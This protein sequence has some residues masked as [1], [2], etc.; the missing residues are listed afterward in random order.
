[1][2]MK[3]WIPLLVFIFLS[4]KGF[5]QDA[6]VYPANVVKINLSSLVLKNI[7]L[8]Y[9]RKLS[10]RISF[11]LGFRIM[12][13]GPIPFRS[14]LLKKSN[15]SGNDTSFKNSITNSRLGGW[16]LTGEVRFYM[17]KKGFARSFYIAPFVRYAQFSL[18]I[19]YT[20][21]DQNGKPYN[22]SLN[23]NL[24]GIG[25]G[26]LLGK[27]WLIGKRVSVDLWL[28]GPF[29]G[30]ANA[31]ANA[32]TDLSGLSDQDKQNLKNKIQ[33]VNLPMTTITANVSN[34]GVQA[35]GVG[36]FGGIRGLGLNV[37]IAF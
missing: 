15:S 11:G 2:R 16:A 27:E 1:M 32:S 36:P 33:N 3:L 5:S 6:E 18:V 35:T 4:L 17:G 23:G 21:T 28:F 10:R 12:P 34:S 19:P 14:V 29:Y 7:G 8:Q 22:L 13:D 9:E 31:T 20:Y 24:H 26:F 37:G 30:R 25:G